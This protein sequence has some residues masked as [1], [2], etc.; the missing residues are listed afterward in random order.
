MFL[1]M[2]CDLIMHY[3]V[4]FVKCILEKKKDPAKYS[5]QYLFKYV[6]QKIILYFLKTHTENS[7]GNTFAASSVILFFFGAYFRLHYLASPYA[8]RAIS[9]TFALAVPL[10]DT[11]RLKIQSTKSE[12]FSLITAMSFSTKSP[13]SP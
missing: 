12:S 2:I 9:A 11:L 10:S 8:T 5:S 1:Y 4:I 7:T 13:Y 6:F 3:F